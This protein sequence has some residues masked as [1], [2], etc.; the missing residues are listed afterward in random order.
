[1]KS[2]LEQN[3]R[4]MYSTHNKGIS[5]LAERFI[6]ALKNKSYKYMTSISKDMCID[7]LNN[8]ANKFNNT[9]HI[10]LKM[11]PVDVKSNINIH[12]GKK[13]NREDPKFKVYDHV[14]ISEHKSSF[15]ID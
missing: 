6:R 2:W 3:N 9:C 13:N 1:M 8:I 10:K 7:K 15:T 4:E 11:K 14:R 12:F 5:F